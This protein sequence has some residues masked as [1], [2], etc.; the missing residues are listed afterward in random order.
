MQLKVRLQITLMIGLIKLL[1]VCYDA[2][3]SGISV[4]GHICFSTR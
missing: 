4:D 3:K 1:E 2:A